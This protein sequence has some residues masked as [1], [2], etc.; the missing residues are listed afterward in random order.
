VFVLKYDKLRVMWTI[1]LA[2]LLY[3]GHM[4]PILLYNR[5]LIMFSL[6]QAVEVCHIHGVGCLSGQEMATCDGSCF[7]YGL[8]SFALLHIMVTV[9]MLTVG[10]LKQPFL[11]GSWLLVDKNY[12]LCFSCIS[13]S[14]PR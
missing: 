9:L 7:I 11:V 10:G 5:Q 4:K 13:L 2:K 3:L 6:M 12:K 1:S 8:D 14:F